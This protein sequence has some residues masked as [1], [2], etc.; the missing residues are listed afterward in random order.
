MLT[1]IQSPFPALFSPQDLL[2]YNKASNVYI[3]RISHL[4]APLENK[5]HNIGVL[6]IWEVMTAIK[7]VWHVGDAQ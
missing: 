3:Y 4:S 6:F 2:L 5:L 7:S 1:H